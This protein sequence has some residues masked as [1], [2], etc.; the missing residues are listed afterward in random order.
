MGRQDFMN[1]GFY[2]KLGETVG[3]RI[4]NKRFIRRY[5]VPNQPNTPAQLDAR[6]LFATATR[7]AQEA[8]NVN[9]GDAAWSN[10]SKSEFS[11][12]VGVAMNR[13]KRGMSEADALPLYP[14]GFVNVDTMHGMGLM[15]GSPLSLYFFTDYVSFPAG[16]AFNCVLSGWNSNNQQ[17]QYTAN[18][19]WDGSLPR[20][21]KFPISGLDLSVMEIDSFSA[22]HEPN[23]T[24][25]TRVTLTDYD[26]DFFF[27]NEDYDASDVKN[28]TMSRSSDTRITLTLPYVLDWADDEY[29]CAV[30]ACNGVNDVG[31]Y[32]FNPAISRQ[33]SS[34]GYVTIPAPTLAGK[35]NVFVSFWAQSANDRF[36]PYWCYKAL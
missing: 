15:L 8:F 29:H 31:A 36:N 5:V 9:K 11:H 30:F 33:S 35:P 1:G 7:L 27:L 22:V 25:N 20:A 2:G 10:Y 19:V 4:G 6:A 28:V 32:W 21:L 13:L 26:P 3:Y 17:V 24:F 18:V 16:T 23:L 34:V 14:D 12:R